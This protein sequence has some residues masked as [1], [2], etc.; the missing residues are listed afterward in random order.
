MIVEVIEQQLLMPGPLVFGATV[1]LYP[2]L[3]SA[4]AR[5]VR[6]IHGDREV[7]RLEES[8][9]SGLVGSK[10]GMLGIPA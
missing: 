5:Q 9:L 6:R 7:A 8:N 10:S 4:A 1:R 2:K 3:N